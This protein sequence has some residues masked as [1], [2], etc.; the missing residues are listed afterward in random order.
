MIKSAEYLLSYN[1]NSMV[2]N[3]IVS[4]NYN[5]LCSSLL[6]VHFI[7]IIYNQIFNYISHFFLSSYLYNFEIGKVKIIRLY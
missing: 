5:I 7:S 6:Q 1:Q 4:L 2:I 3:N